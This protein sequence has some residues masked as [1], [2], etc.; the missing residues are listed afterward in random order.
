M[1][2][3]Q[4]ELN[5]L[6]DVGLPGAFVYIEDAEGSS[7]FHT[8]GFADLATRQHMAPDSRYHVGSTT[9]TFTAVV[10]L[11]LIAEGRLALHDT[12]QDWLPDLP[13]PNASF[14]TI[15]HLLRMRSG[16]FDFEDDPS[17]LGSL[18]AH[19]QPYSLQHAIDLGIK[20]PANFAPGARHEYCNTNFCVLE[21]IIERITGNSLAEEFARR[22]FAPLGMASS[23]YPAEDDLALPEPYIRGYDRTA[24]G[25][26]ECSHSFVGHGDGALISTALDLAR[27]FRALLLERKLLPD[28][29]LEQMLSIVPDNPP[30]ERAYGLGLIAD[31]LPCSTVWGHSGGVFGYR[32]LPYL[33][34]ETGLFAVFMLNGTY[35]FRLKTDPS[36][37][38][39]TTFSKEMRAMAY[40]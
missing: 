16:L 35:G 8:S 25:W 28:G 26:R 14:L 2:P 1:H 22:I 27:F 24:E 18:E 15:E 33:Q 11:Q 40:G 37:A 17:L 5:R 38:K 19:L 34:L 4:I 20:H 23:S 30:A 21:S 9:K 13:V 7:R 32:H 39:R 29:L 12:M 3:I 31:S 36:S 6:V 10:T